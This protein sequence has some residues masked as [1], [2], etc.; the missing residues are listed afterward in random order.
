MGTTCYVHALIG[1]IRR[2]YMDEDTKYDR[3]SLRGENPAVPKDKN[4][5]FDFKHREIYVYIGISS[6]SFIGRG[7]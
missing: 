4:E 5:Y 6:I 2:I 7:P 3:P 1:G